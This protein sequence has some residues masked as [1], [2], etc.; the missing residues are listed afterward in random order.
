MEGIRERT[1]ELGQEANDTTVVRYKYAKSRPFPML[2]PLTRIQAPH[3]TMPHFPPLPLEGTYSSHFLDCADGERRVGSLLPSPTS[4]S[5]PRQGNPSLAEDVDNARAIDRRPA[6]C[7][8]SSELLSSG[9][10]RRVGRARRQPRP[11]SLGCSWLRQRETVVVAQGCCLPASLMNKHTIWQQEQQ[12]L[13]MHKPPS[14]C[15][16]IVLL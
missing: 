11:A 16:T 15:P 8:L 12:W 2:G 14:I 9:I 5:L 7:T 10:N 13:W 4:P 1:N 3:H 6:Y